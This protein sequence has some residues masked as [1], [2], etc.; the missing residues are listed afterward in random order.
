MIKPKID[1]TAFVAKGAAVYGNVTLGK[2]SNVGS[3]LLCY[4][5]LIMSTYN[6]LLLACLFVLNL[7]LVL[8][9]CAPK[10]SPLPFPRCLC[11]R[12]NHSW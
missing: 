6:A 12:D 11:S 1:P 8:C 7:C 3:S 9:C 2:E 4:I 10:K 5:L